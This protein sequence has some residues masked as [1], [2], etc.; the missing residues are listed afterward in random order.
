MH[1]IVSA[2]EPV[3]EIRTSRATANRWRHFEHLADPPVG[4]V[5]LGD[6]AACFNPMNGQGIS[7]ACYGAK[8]LVE[9]IT[10]LDGDIEKVSQAFPGRLA[11]RM[12]FPWQ[13]ALGFDFQFTTTSGERPPVTPETKEQARYMKALGELITAD[14]DA[15]EALFLWTQTFDPGQIRRPEIVAKVE[16]WVADGRRPEYT[17]PAIPPPNPDL[18]S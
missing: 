2:A 1:Q 15:A 12:E 11:Q 6:A 4:Y 5:A 18:A 16:A 7:T 10:D 9:T 13:V 14:A 3:S 17:D 8:T